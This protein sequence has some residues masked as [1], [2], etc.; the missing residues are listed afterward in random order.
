MLP[1]A[2]GDTGAIRDGDDLVVGKTYEHEGEL[3]LCHSGYHASERAL[4]AL[5]YAP[6]P[7]ACR[8]ELSG[9]IRRGDDK[10]VASQRKV[11]AAVDATKLLHEFA[12][13]CA[14]EALRVGKVDD[15]RSW[16]AIKVK[17]DWLEGKA[18]DAELAAA[19]DAA[20]DAAWTAAWDEQNTWLERRLDAAL[21]ATE[22]GT[23]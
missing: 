4:G 23:L 21:G 14:E 2:E 16:N 9:E 8:V 12:C 20:R 15:K 17:R 7:I 18:T 22:A 6:G 5:N 13:D 11:I 3:L 10:L 19:R 1:Q